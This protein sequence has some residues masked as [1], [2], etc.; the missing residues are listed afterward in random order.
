MKSPVPNHLDRRD[1][2]TGGLLLGLGGLLQACAGR[3]GMPDVVFPKNA[4]GDGAF[5]RRPVTPAAP[6]SSAS[7]SAPGSGQGYYAL[8][9]E[10]IPR[11][12]WTSQGINQARLTSNGDGGRM[13][14]ITRITVHHDALDNSSLR[15]DGDVIRRLSSIRLGHVSRRPEPFADIGYHFIIDPKGQVWEGRSTCYQGA[16]VRGQNENNLGIMLLG[17]FDRNRPTPAAIATLEAFVILQ[18]HRYGVSATRVRT[19]QE[20][21]STECPGRYLQRAMVA[22]RHRGGAIYSA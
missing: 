6:P 9:P 21:A 15:T 14:R 20:L 11:S 19:H 13:G 18:M 7:T 3:T 22:S 2:L 1:V 12:R 17:H 10:V 16:H 4:P 5:V 8:P